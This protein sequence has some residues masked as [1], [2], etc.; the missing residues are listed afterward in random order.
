MTA[1]KSLRRRRR[2]AD[3]PKSIPP[4]LAAWF[5][6]RGP[7]PWEAL[8]VEEY[9]RMPAWWALW[10][11]DHPDAEPPTDAPWISFDAP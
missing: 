3:G 11:R 4:G 5:A 1:P 2:P 8:L 6:G 10:L 7:V 9:H